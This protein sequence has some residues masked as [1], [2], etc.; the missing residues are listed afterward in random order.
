MDNP[1]KLAN[2]IHETTKNMLIEILM[3]NYI[4]YSE[5]LNEQLSII[6]RKTVKMVY[7]LLY[8]F[9][10]PYINVYVYT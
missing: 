4:K 6:N 9:L 10:I 1:E 2:R 7:L 5:K 8:W 3:Y